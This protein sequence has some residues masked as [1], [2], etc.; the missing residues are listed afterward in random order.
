MLYPWACPFCDGFMFVSF[1][2]RSQSDVMIGCAGFT[3]LNKGQVHPFSK[4]TQLIVRTRK[5]QGIHKSARK[6]SLELQVEDA[7]TEAPRT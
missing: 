4:S 2:F 7:N 5:L 6:L 3:P 1:W